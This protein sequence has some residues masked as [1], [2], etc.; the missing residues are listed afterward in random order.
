METLSRLQQWYLDQCDGDWEHHYGVKIDTL[1]NPGWTLKV[2]LTGTSAE[3]H[4]LDRVTIER[5]END[6]IHYRVENKQFMAAMGPQNLT[7]GI[8]AFLGWIQNPK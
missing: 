5:T 4:L 6:W 2:D 7:E 3:D 8:E 1:D